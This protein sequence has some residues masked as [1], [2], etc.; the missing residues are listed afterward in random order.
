MDS[1]TNMRVSTSSVENVT[2]WKTT[3]SV[4]TSFFKHKTKWNNIQLL[5]K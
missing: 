3:E 4:T 2:I 1:G 5:N